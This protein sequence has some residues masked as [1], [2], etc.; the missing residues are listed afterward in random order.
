MG[1]IALDGLGL[2]PDGWVVS[3]VGHQHS[4]DRCDPNPDNHWAPNRD[5]NRDYRLAELD[6][7][8]LVR[9]RGGVRGGRVLNVLFV[10]ECEVTLGGSGAE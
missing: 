5:A 6:G 7:G 9:L 3:V 10:S 4:G 2:D 1:V 8:H